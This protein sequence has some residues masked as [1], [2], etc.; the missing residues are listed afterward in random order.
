ME[1][2]EFLGIV[3]IG[4]ALSMAIQFIKTKFGVDTLKTKAL[5]L[6]L[7]LLLGTRYYFAVQTIWWQNALS[8]LGIASA[9]WAFF[10][11]DK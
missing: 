2:Q 9:F 8:I 5:T 4:V 3:I 6:T 11:R 7:A 10:L 1:I